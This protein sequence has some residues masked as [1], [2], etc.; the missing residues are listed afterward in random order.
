MVILTIMPSLIQFFYQLNSH[1]TNLQSRIMNFK[2]KRLSTFFS[3]PRAELPLK[4]QE[5]IMTWTTSRV[6]NK[7]THSIHWSFSWTSEIIKGTINEAPVTLLGRNQMRL[8][9]ICLWNHFPYVLQW[10]MTIKWKLPQSRRELVIK[11]S[12]NPITTRSSE[13]HKSKY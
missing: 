7:S 8:V 2:R 9:P 12:I 1:P 13:E 6:E 11:N 3:K 10:K 4:S 5:I